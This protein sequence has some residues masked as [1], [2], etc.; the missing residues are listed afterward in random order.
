MKLSHPETGVVPSS[1]IIVQ[2][3]NHVL[4]STVKIAEAGDRI[5]PGLVN[6]NGHINKPEGD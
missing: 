3:C 6:R 1:W 5:V 4:D 2:D